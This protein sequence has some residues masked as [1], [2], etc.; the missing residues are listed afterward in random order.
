MPQIRVQLGDFTFTNLEVPEVIPWGGDQALA[1][2]KLIGG[3]RIID[4]MGRDD[5][6]LSWEGV[7]LDSTAFDRAQYLDTLRIAGQAL[8]L[9]WGQLNF[10]VVIRSFSADFK[11]QYNIPYRISCEVVQD[12]ATPTVPGQVPNV[13]DQM[14][15][16]MATAN[17]LGSG[18]GDGVLSGLL[19]TLNTAIS[20]VST[21]ANASNS[22]I[23]SVLQPIAAV[24]ARTKILLTSV[25]NTTQNI[26]TVGGVLPNTPLAQ[27]VNSMAN[28]TGAFEQQPL[29][30]SLQ[31]TM[32]RMAANT[33]SVGANTSTVN[34]AGGSLYAIAASEY[35]DASSWVAIAQANGMTDPQIQGL[36]T[37]AVPKLPSVSGGVLGG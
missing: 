17:G 25:M 23:Q 9:T 11:F 8:P 32:G 16:D 26:G 36:K 22:V 28:Q 4:A 15:S 1:I 14:A 31:S 19:G 18:I 35:G 29:L 6:A 34:T 13:D 20:A 37:L 24:Q 2:Q 3:A 30:L 33:N 27:N 10:T 7:F 5:M 12:N 21:F